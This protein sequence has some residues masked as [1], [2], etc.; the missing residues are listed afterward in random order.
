VIYVA[1]EA[2]FVS[3][4]GRN[5]VRLSFSAPTP[6]RIEEGIARLARAVRAELAATSPAVSS[7]EGAP[8]AAR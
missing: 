5:I 4:A 6:E 2:F 1:G 8:R 3:R 7:P